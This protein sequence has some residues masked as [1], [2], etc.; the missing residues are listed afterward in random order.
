MP[1][2][3]ELNSALFVVG[4]IDSGGNTIEDV[5]NSYGHAP[6]G[7]LYN[8]QDLVQGEQLLVQAG[9]LVERDGM[10]VP[11]TE[12][13]SLTQLD[14]GEANRLL[15]WRVLNSASPVWLSTA[16]SP[17]AVAPELV[18]GDEWDRLDQIVTPEEREALL[19][20]LGR[21][22]DPAATSAVGALG[23]ETVAEA[24]KA[25]L[26]E[27]GHPHLAEQVRRVSLISDQLG[28]DVVSPGHDEGSRRMEVKTTT[29]GPL[30][31]EII[32]SRNEVEVG[33]ADPA[34]RLVV[35]RSEG[36]SCTIAGWCKAADVE[37]SLPRDVVTTG[38]WTAASIQLRAEV[39]RPG[40]PLG[41]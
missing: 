35:C 38:R 12:A 30:V 41:N 3:H 21:R 1:T 20:S 23:E 33:L 32:L 8:A 36:E 37:A 2:L 10:L 16:I 6:S 22:V 7:G 26:R 4:L 31:F 34:W 9:F 40:V 18:P 13:L 27:R 25:H 39:L 14:L 11:S 5:R 24:C 15:T 29:S 28:Y 17:G 19:L